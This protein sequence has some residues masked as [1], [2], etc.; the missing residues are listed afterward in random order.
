[1]ARYRAK[2]TFCDGIVGTIYRGNIAEIPDRLAV[3]FMEL[4]YI[5]PYAQ[6][7]DI[8]KPAPLPDF[9]SRVAKIEKP[10]PIPAF[11]QRVK[12]V[13]EPAETKPKRKYVR[14]RSTSR[15]K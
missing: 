10:D 7:P 6:T 9:A 11:E 13:V 14:K 15:R 5:E 4:G 12:A 2:V 8:I 3:R 1:M